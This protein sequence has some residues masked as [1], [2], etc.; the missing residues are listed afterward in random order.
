MSSDMHRATHFLPRLT[1]TLMVRG[2]S[3]RAHPTLWVSNIMRAVVLE[4]I[5]DGDRLPD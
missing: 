4:E 2:T 3:E 1:L 5:K